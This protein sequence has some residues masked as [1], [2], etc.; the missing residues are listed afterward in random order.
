VFIY[1]LIALLVQ[2]ALHVVSTDLLFIPHDAGESA[3]TLP[4]IDAFLAGTNNATNITVLTL[5]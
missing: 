5:E 2:A 1:A 3:F 4:I